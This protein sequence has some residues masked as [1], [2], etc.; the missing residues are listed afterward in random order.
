M[1]RI[2]ESNE[3]KLTS[4]GFV[5]K[6]SF[7]LLDFSQISILKIS[8]KFKLIL[9]ENFDL[10]FPEVSNEVQHLKYLICY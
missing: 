2:E 1:K 4:L 9:N 5:L 7:L 3:F 10:P 6:I 8:F